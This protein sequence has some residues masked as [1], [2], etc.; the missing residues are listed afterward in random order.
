MKKIHTRGTAALAL[1]ASAA[2]I[3][4]GCATF[5]SSGGDN[6]GDE[7]NTGSTDVSTEVPDE[8]ITLTVSY[9]DPPTK[10]LAKGFED[11]HSNVTVKV[12]Q[13]PFSDYIKSIKRAMSS[14]SPPDIAEYNPGAMRSLIPAHLVLNLDPYSKAYGWDDAFPAGSLEALTASDDAKEFNTGHLYATPGAMSLLGV[15]YNKA[16]LS[17]AGI[18]NPPATLDEFKDDLAT[19]KDAGIQPFSVG[20]LEVGGFQLWNALANVLGDV[21]DY[22]N[23][24]YGA[25]GATIE[26]DG[27]TEAAKLI[28]EWTKSG[29]IP[30]GASA[31]SDSDALANFTGG[32]SAFLVTGN[33]N[34]AKVEK[35]LG[36][37]AGFFL[38]PD[39]SADAPPVASGGSVAY[40]ISAKTKHPD[41]AAAFLNYM[42]TA[43]AA[44]A[45]A[46]AGFLP[47]ST[48]GDV[49]YSPLGQTVADAFKAVAGGD[50]VV[51]FPDY[52]S[53][54]MIDKLESGVQGLITG[55]TDAE[56]FV[57]SLQSEWSSYH[58]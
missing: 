1:T 57:K 53:P 4:S 39:T 21:Q 41:A 46:D 35:A 43:E 38:M 6:S 42:A 10:A 18:D 30:K 25:D 9:V 8:D 58:E 16:L 47:V 31:V 27:A 23:W 54:G 7:S 28:S 51:S 3:L 44:P 48:E 5:G 24:V 56:S 37:D 40:S 49:D 52:A 50:G 14:D 29:Y 26:T 15:F 20:G 32:N 22:K 2:L 13:V 12:T 36:D 34:V 17:K 55:H 19:L 11:K 45:E 33:W